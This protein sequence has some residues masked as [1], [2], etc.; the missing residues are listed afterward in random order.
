[1]PFMTS[2]D[3]DQFNPLIREGMETLQAYTNPDPIQL[4]RRDEVS[5]NFTNAGAPFTPIDVRLADR[6]EQVGG[7]NTGR[8]EVVNGGTMRAFAP[9]DVRRDDRFAY[10]DATAV[11]TLV[12]DEV[13][14]GYVTVNFRLL[15][16]V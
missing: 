6:M 15:G 8:V 11:V 7:A 12:E 9:L 3:F 4:R 1:M 13:R 5:G 2:A 16:G 10:N 14:G